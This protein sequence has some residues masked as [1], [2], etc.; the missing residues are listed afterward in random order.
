MTR[1]CLTTGSEARGG[2]ISSGGQ[3]SFLNGRGEGAGVRTGRWVHAGCLESGVAAR[4]LALPPQSKGP[5]FGLLRQR[6][7]VNGDGALWMAGE[8][9]RGVRTGRW[10]HAGCLESGAPARR[11]ALPPQSKG[12]VLL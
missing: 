12:L 9:A 11:L 1:N 5:D 2:G 7:L 8:R 10:V 4:R 6:E 3:Q